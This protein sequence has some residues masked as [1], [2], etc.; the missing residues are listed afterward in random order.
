MSLWFPLKQVCRLQLHMLYFL[1]I[2][3]VYSQKKDE[4]HILISQPAKLEALPQA[5]F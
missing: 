2:C 4:A 1:A 3:T 5:E